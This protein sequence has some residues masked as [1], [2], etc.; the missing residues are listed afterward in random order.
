MPPPWK[1]KVLKNLDPAVRNWSGYPT[2]WIGHGSS[3]IYPIYFN[4]SLGNDLGTDPGYSYNFDAQQITENISIPSTAYSVNDHFQDK[5]YLIRRPRVIRVIWDMGWWYFEQ[6]PMKLTASGYNTYNESIYFT[7]PNVGPGGIENTINYYNDFTS[8]INSF[9]TA[10]KITVSHAAFE[11]TGDWTGPTQSPI[12]YSSS[13]RP[14]T[15]Y[16]PINIPSRWMFNLIPRYRWIGNNFFFLT[17]PLGNP[18][19]IEPDHEQYIVGGKCLNVIFCTDGYSAY[20]GCSTHVFNSTLTDLSTV[21]NNAMMLEDIDVIKRRSQYFD[22]WGTILVSSPKNPEF[23]PLWLQDDST[24]TNTFTPQAYA[25]YDAQIHFN[26]VAALL[27]GY[28]FT[29]LVRT[30]TMIT[31]P[32]PRHLIYESQSMGFSRT[33]ISVDEIM[34]EVEAFWAG[35]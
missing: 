21:G 19:W 8:A 14:D 11:N 23:F 1:N 33:Q 20:H 32:T 22:K 15:A 25:F 4:T 13:F 27:S 3:A 31:P 24:S 18:S 16:R 26:S 10:N 5:G 17:T 12:T 2:Y 7:P 28:N 34:T 6:F 9:G 30:T 29:P 35:E